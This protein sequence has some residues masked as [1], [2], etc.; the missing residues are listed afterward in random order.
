MSRLLSAFSSRPEFRGPRILL[1]TT[2]FICLASCRPAW[3]LE[4]LRPSLSKLAK[5]I[6]DHLADESATN[7]TLGAVTGQADFNPSKGP[8]IKRILQEELHELGIEECSNATFEVK[9]DYRATVDKE[10]SAVEGIDIP[11]ILLSVTIIS[12]RTGARFEL[13]ASIRDQVDVNPEEF[14]DLICELFGIDSGDHGAG[15]T[16]QQ[17][18]PWFESTRARMIQAKLEYRARVRQGRQPI[19]FEQSGPYRVEILVKTRKGYDQRPLEDQGVAF[20]DLNRG[21]QYAVKL[22][23]DSEH[24]AAVTLTIDGLNVFAFS[25][26]NYQHFIVPRKGSTVVKGWHRTNEWSEAFLITRYSESEAAKSLACPSDEVGTITAQFA[27]AWESREE[28]PHDEEGRAKSPGGIAT[29]RGPVTESKFEEVRRYVGR[30]R[31]T[32]NVRYD[33]PMVAA[34]YP[35]TV[36]GPET[37]R[38]EFDR[39]ASS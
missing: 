13:A 4:G 29:Q 37:E 1:V 9:M 16:I 2:A 12:K 20:V 30:T 36:R 6:R 7:V 39:Q 3:A 18:S 31:A 10:R 5:N 32:I 15:M 17:F 35:V 38:P 11:Q 27:A 23:N 14:K 21:E 25:E 26:H 19:P 24:D 8:G 22:I 28:E 34:P 33:K